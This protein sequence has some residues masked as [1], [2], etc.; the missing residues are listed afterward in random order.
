MDGDAT[1]A[2]L[3]LMEGANPSAA[4][5][6]GWTPLHTAAMNCRKDCVSMLL[7]WHANPNSLTN[8][9]M[10]PLH[11]LARS[12]KDVSQ[13][14]LQVR[15]ISCLEI[16]EALI[17]AGVDPSTRDR[18]GCNALHMAGLSNNQQLVRFLLGHILGDGSAVVDPAKRIRLC[19]PI[20]T[21]ECVEHALV[22]AQ[23]LAATLVIQASEVALAERVQ[24]GNKRPREYD[25]GDDQHLPE[26]R[27]R[28]E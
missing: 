15:E 1:I 9:G 28:A 27:Y 8:N 3:L 23:G 22:N 4:D 11:C 24:A 17:C 25:G 6:S 26:R 2:M 19:D 10:T 16:A 5:E 20:L 14:L 21:N 13:S 18:E 12:H 7:I